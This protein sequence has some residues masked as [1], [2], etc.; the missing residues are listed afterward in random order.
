MKMQS[1][2]QQTTVA[3]PLPLS[4]CIILSQD[5]GIVRLSD[6]PLEEYLQ[7]V[8]T[9]SIA[10]IDFS[11]PANDQEIERIAHIAGFSKIPIPKLTTGF[12]SA[13]ED[14]DTELGIMFP[15]VTVKI[16]KMTVHPLFILIRDNL[17]LT[18]H[19]EE[20]NRLLRF[21]RYA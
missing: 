20:I 6:R 11:I 16:E 7:E 1:T 15:S 3:V 17:V 9:A 5:N 2:Q 8:C 14:Y 18:V 4:F 19:S 12:Y 21:S 10:W 13:Y